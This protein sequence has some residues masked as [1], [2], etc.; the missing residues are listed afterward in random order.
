MEKNITHF[1]V[2]FLETWKEKTI[3]Y[4]VTGES[5]DCEMGKI[6][7]VE[8]INSTAKEYSIQ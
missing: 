6:I 8:L 4:I 2:F 7:A 1:Q 3:S 5:F